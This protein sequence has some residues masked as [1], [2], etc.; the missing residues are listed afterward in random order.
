MYRLGTA[1]AGILDWLWPPAIET[2]RLRT[3]PGKSISCIALCSPK[4]SVDHYAKD[5][6]SG[7]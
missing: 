7:D 4:C 6:A 2:D 1:L 3:G 5:L